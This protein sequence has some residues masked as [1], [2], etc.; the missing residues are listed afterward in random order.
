MKPLGDAPSW[1][2]PEAPSPPRTPPLLPQ[3]KTSGFAIAS[4]VFGLIGGVL[5]SVIFGIIGL[6][7]IKR[8]GLRGR[9]FAIAGFVL[10]GLWT[11]LIV[12]GVVA[13][14]LT[15]PER[16]VGGRVTDSGSESV[17]DLRVG[18]CMNGLEETA[19]RFTVDVTPCADSHDAEAVFEFNL[20]DGDWP[21]MPSVTHAATRRCLNEVASAATGAPRIGE[22]EAFYLHPTEES[23][24]SQ[25]DRTVLCIA[26]YPEP[27]TGQL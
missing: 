18:D 5:L 13:F 9:G 12:V 27:R 16:D 3:G 7:R 24:Q 1:P 26:L 25:D 6:R 15:E 20:P 19:A 10:S 17:F 8:R 14:L 21:G 4:L 11:L 2:R 23:W 22:I